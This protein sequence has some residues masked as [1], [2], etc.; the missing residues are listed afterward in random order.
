MP[1]IDTFPL[2]KQRDQTDCG[3][4]CLLSVIKY[5]NGD[6][7]LERLRELSGTT[8]QGTSILGLYQAAQTEGLKADAFKVTNLDEFSQEATFPCI[9]HVLID[10]KLEHFV[11]CVKP[12]TETEDNKWLIANPAKGI[13]SW[14]T[15]ELEEKWKSRSVLLLQPN[16]NFVKVKQA[17]HKKWLW[18]WSLIKFDVA[19][20]T[21]A[22]VLGICISIL[23]LSSA[24][25]SQKLVD[26]ILPKHQTQKLMLGLSILLILLLSKAGLGYLR[27]FFLIRQ[28]KEFNNRIA[29]SFYD[30]L[31]S[32]PKSFFDTRK[33]G[34]LIARMND[35]R[36]IQQT[37]SY[38]AGT[39][40]IDFLVVIVSSIVVFQY[41]SWV[42]GVSILSIPLFGILAWRYSNGILRGQ[43]NV[44]G[45][46]AR[47]ESHYVDTITGISALKATNRTGYFVD[48]T[49]SINSF[50]QQNIYNLSLLGNRYNLLGELIAVFL[51]GII[52]ALASW[53]VLNKQ[54]LIGQ[55]LATVSIASGLISSVARLAN[56][57]IQLQE[58]RVA[59]ERMYEFSSLQSEFDSS[60][61][62]L[63]ESPRVINNL[64]IKNL[65]FRF[66]GRSLLLKDVSLTIERGKITVLMGEVGSGKSLVLQILQQFQAIESGQI[67]INNAVSLSDISP[68]FWRDTIGI[69]PQ[70]IKIF[71]SSILENIILANISEEGESAVNFCEAIGL[72]Q[73][74]RQLPQ[75]YFTIVGE[76]GINLSGGQKQLIAL[77]RALY[78][79]PKVLLLDEATSAMDSQTEHFVLTLLEKL[80]SDMGILMVTHRQSIANNADKIYHLSN[81]I[82]QNSKVSI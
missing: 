3:V 74:F 18:L 17:E 43:Q 44:M 70:E 12:N 56:T 1:T 31:F 64:I 28:S 10:D 37:I 62:T 61:K 79:K 49:K 73:F 5:H 27:N 25:F 34:D 52:L 11:V 24:L 57:N 15:D 81:G 23:G 66:A 36:R 71:N 33:T 30:S 47:T 14:T 48:I 4:A 75:S 46:Y 72:G 58:A 63:Q 38:L 21:I 35:T 53:Q 67:L 41:S 42:G 40:F 54:F 26:D 45:S 39:V 77:A 6:M 59:F 68:I 13:E 7:S 19:L 50:F 60:N 76:E 51:L 16:Q 29:G 9:L 22:V 82:I 80:K 69:V 20:L 55:M 2:V 78:R 8:I 32:L 65:S